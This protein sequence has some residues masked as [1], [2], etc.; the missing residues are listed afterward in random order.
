MLEL[1]TLSGGT[2]T[3]PSAEVE[4]LAARLEG[5]TT[6]TEDHPDYDDARAVWNG[7]IDRRP[8]LIVRCAAT[9]DVHAAVGFAREHEAL[10]AVRGGGH[11]VAGSAVC[12]GGVV[13]DLSPMN[14]VR[15]DPARLTVHAGG[16]ATI[17][18]LDRETQRHG[19][20]VP[21]GVVSETGIA[22]LTLGGGLG[23]LRRRYGM[24]CDNLLGAEVVTA[25]GG[26][27][28]AGPDDE[29]DLLWAL[30]GGGGNF[31]VVTGFEF[32]AHPVG[33]ETYLLFTLHPGSRAADGL[34]HFREWAAAAPEEV[35]AFAVL[36]HG[37]DA[38]PIPAEHRGRPVLGLVAV[39][40]GDPEEGE[41]ALAPLRAFGSPI[42]DDSGPRPYLDI[43]RY[44]DADYPARE[45]RYYW[46]S[47][48]L[49]DLPDEAV[50]TLVKLNESSPSPHSNIDVWQ[51]GGAAARV[52]AAESAFG[53]RSAPYLAGIE[54][55][56]ERPGDD[57][58][59]LAWAR[60]TY[61]ELEP[62]AA[63]GEYANFPGF[64]ENRETVLRDNFGGNLGRLT[65][66]KR[67]YDPANL[68]R[69]N[70]NIRP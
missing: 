63:G 48:F 21:M 33:P 57:D 49:R 52:P 27:L 60:D 16:G 3:V 53:D 12:D 40:S 25:D 2:A 59:C 9:A 43:Q 56:W 8:A 39:H 14:E 32:R 20:A 41:R 36:W 47:R 23:W 19:L 24:S 37:P 38:D 67:R 4:A 70:H 34:R 15:A 11:N 45:M 61:R 64:Y 68:F 17:G 55:N 22:G 69:L 5:G 66:L 46:K 51:L 18:D 44:F 50:E 13:V 65:E 30:R 62:Y 28:R 54:A 35:S 31:G 42:V 6:L 58:A 1:R 29:P 10:L 7:L 26:V